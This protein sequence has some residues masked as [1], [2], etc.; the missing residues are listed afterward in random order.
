LE[1]SGCIINSDFTYINKVAPLLDPVHFKEGGKISLLG[2]ESLT[3]EFIGI[4][5]GKREEQIQTAKDVNEGEGGGANS[6]RLYDEARLIL[7]VAT[8]L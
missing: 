3:L 6:Y 4:L 7:S 8:V 5:T 1:C 2:C